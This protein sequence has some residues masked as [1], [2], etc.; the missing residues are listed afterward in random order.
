MLR[1]LLC[2]G[3]L[4]PF[5]GG[6]R[7]GKER[8]KVEKLGLNSRPQNQLKLTYLIPRNGR[9]PSAIQIPCCDWHRITVKCGN[10]KSIR[11][12]GERGGWGIPCINFLKPLN[13]NKCKYIH[14]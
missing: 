1:K 7:D 8:R 9:L 6:G 10:F 12:E 11:D 13:S 2:A 5:L 14:S 3:E 4:H